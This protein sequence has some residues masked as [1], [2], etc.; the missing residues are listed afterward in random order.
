MGK[1]IIKFFFI[2][3]IHLFDYFVLLEFLV[4]EYRL[5]NNKIFMTLTL[6]L[7]INLNNFF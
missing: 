7:L 5:Y 3:P 4:Y 6:L 2:I 1:K